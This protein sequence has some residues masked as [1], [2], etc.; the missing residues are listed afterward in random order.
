MLIT[1]YCGLWVLIEKKEKKKEI[2]ATTFFLEDL[3]TYCSFSLVIGSGCRSR[4]F[5]KRLT[6][7][8]SIVSFLMFPYSN[9]C[10]HICKGE[11][12]SWLCLKL[13][14]YY[15]II[16]KEHLLPG[17]IVLLLQCSSCMQRSQV[18]SQTRWEQ[19]QR[20]CWLWMQWDWMGCLKGSVLLH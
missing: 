14:F 9:K 17:A 5:R 1:L 12:V 19:G 10:P 6:F 4:Y 7:P 8:R 11:K 16:C 15:I 18:R 20:N 3:L 13:L 2:S